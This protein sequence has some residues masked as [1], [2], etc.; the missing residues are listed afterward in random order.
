MK[1]KHTTGYNSFLSTTSGLVIVD[2]VPH[3]FVAYVRNVLMVGYQ[4]QLSNYVLPFA[5]TEL[6]HASIFF[7]PDYC[8]VSGWKQGREVVEPLMRHINLLVAGTQCTDAV[9]GYVMDGTLY[10]GT[11]EAAAHERRCILLMNG[12]EWRSSVSPGKREA[13]VFVPEPCDV[14][15][16]RINGSG[17]FTPRFRCIG[18]VLVIR[19]PAKASSVHVIH[20]LGDRRS[21]GDYAVTTGTTE[22]SIPITRRLCV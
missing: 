9:S 13:S 10:T 7:W 16:I 3:R 5:P 2:G 21:Y 20:T 19:L 1:I 4:K 12:E 22:L 17:W 14:V 18:D 8:Q 11:I 15:K 6:E